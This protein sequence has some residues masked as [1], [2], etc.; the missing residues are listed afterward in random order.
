MGTS[1]VFIY[2]TSVFEEV[3]IVVFEW[4]VVCVDFV[5]WAAAET[6]KNK[7][8]TTQKMKSRIRVVFNLQNN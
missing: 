2:V 5:G 8:S 3:S 7:S 1:V 6:P 4:T